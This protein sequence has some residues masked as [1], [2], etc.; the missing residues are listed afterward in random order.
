[1]KVLL[2]IS[3]MTLVL[4]LQGGEDEFILI[5]HVGISDKPI[6]SIF[7]SQKPLD[8]KYLIHQYVVKQFIVEDSVYCGLKN[9][10]KLNKQDNI[11]EKALEFG[12]FEFSIHK[13]NKVCI[14]YSLNREKSVQLFNTMIKFL[15]N[16]NLNDKLLIEFETTKKRIIF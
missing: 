9:I 1:M 10:T 8:K 14:D 12:T 5:E 11:E 13:G 15:R 7:I 6:P 2:I 3:I 16:K 4:T